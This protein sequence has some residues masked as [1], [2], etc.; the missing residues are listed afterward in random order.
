MMRSLDPDIIVR[1][2]T[3]ARAAERDAA[4]SAVVVT[5]HDGDLDVIIYTDDRPG[6]LADLA[7]AVA[8]TGMSFR[9]VQALTTNDGKAIDIF[10]IQTP[11]G[12]PVEDLEQGRR[13]HQALLAAASSAPAKPP[14]L[15]RRLGDRRQIFSVAPDV[16]IEP[17]ASEEATVLEAEGLD[18]PGLLFELTQALAE[19]GAII[20]SAHISTYGERAVDAFYLQTRDGEK[21]T[22]PA[23]LA[24]IK[25]SLTAVLAAG[26]DD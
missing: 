12:V 10:V 21:L 2:A 16:R 18:R 26:S 14:Q 25:K 23:A 19:E 8:S 22:D 13:L 1:F 5:P 3:L 24:R 4:H 11:D 17:G 7:G 15:R 20:T 9:S 6:L